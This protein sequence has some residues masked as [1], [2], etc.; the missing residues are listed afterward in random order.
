MAL[1]WLV[2]CKICALRFPVLPREA[3]PGKSTDSLVRHIAA[4]SFECPHCHEVQDYSTD[5]F[6]PGEGRI[7]PTPGAE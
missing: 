4:G 7:M 3:V 1:V 6:I 2:E 5:D